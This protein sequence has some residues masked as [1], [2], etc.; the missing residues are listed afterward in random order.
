MLFR[1]EAGGTHN[2]IVNSHNQYWLAIFVNMEMFSY[3]SFWKILWVGIDRSPNLQKRHVGADDHGFKQHLTT[4]INGH[5]AQILVWR[6]AIPVSSF[7]IFF[8][9]YK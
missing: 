3:N 6:Q 2:D 7:M 1:G 8:E 9:N 5:R 4:A